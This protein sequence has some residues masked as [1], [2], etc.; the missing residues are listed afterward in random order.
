MEKQRARKK[1]WREANKDKVKAAMKAY[2]EANREKLGECYCIYRLKK[3]IPN[4]PENLIQLRLKLRQLHME[5]TAANNTM[6]E[7]L[8]KISTPKTIDDLLIILSTQIDRIQSANCNVAKEAKRAS[9]TAS[10]TRQIFSG[11]RLKLAY[12]K[13]RDEVPAEPKSLPG[14]S[15]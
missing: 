1:A 7:Q 5:I 4:P 12:A 8:T 10:C 9:A 11:L 6:S 3:Q 2:Y 15:E 14:K 13:E